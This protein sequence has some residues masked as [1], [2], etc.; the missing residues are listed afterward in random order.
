MVYCNVQTLQHKDVKKC[1]HQYKH[2]CVIIIIIIIIIII[3]LE[4]GQGGKVTILW[5]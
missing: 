1:N 5:N 3:K 2:A 4:I